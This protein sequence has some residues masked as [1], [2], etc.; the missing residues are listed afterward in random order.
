VNIGTFDVIIQEGGAYD[1]RYYSVVGIKW[2]WNLFSRIALQG[3]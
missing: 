3:L 2:Y 1:C